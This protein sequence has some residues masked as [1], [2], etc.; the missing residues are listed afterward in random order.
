MLEQ[1]E[2][3]INSDGELFYRG[4]KQ[5]KK[6]VQQHMLKQE[7]RVKITREP[8]SK[9][10]GWVTLEKPYEVHYW[11]F[12]KKKIFSTTEMREMHYARKKLG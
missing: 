6:L 5:L 10:D 1:N 4:K 9:G 12:D 11:S 2:D 7:A 8:N 3:L